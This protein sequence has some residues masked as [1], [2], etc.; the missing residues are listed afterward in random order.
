MEVS[1]PLM[2]WST[3]MVKMV[4]TLVQ[5]FKIQ[6]RTANERVEVHILLHLQL[7]QCIIIIPQ[8]QIPVPVEG[9]INLPQMR[10]YNNQSGEHVAISSHG[11]R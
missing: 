11:T 3:K 1:S 2:S 5:E 7:L 6:Q 8:R 4:I 10:S 9:S